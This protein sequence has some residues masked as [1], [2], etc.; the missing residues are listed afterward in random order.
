MIAIAEHAEG[1]VLAVRAQPGA[2]RNALVGELNG[3]LKVA[4]TA[5]ADQGKANQALAEVLA[6][7]LGLKRAQVELLA[8]ATQRGKRFLLRGITSAQLRARLGAL[9]T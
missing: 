9:G 5:P 7:R 3:A 2:K 1:C 4:V 6:D 8:G